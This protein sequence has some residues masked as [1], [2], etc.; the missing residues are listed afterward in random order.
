MLA[1]ASGKGG[2][3]KTTTALGLAASLPARPLVVD[4][5]RAMPNLHEM[6]D[7]SRQPS[8]DDVLASPTAQPQEAPAHDCRVLP[9]PTSE[10]VRIDLVCSRL[11]QS[12]RWDPSAII[13]DCPAG[14]SIDAAAP[15]SAADAVVLVSTACATA[16]RDTA[17]TASMARAVDTSVLGVVL[18]R[19]RLQPPGVESL[20]DAPVLARVPPVEGDPL[21]NRCVRDRYRAAAHRLTERLG[22]GESDSSSTD[23]RRAENVFRG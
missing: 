3:G 23:V 8:V 21:S 2:V 17:K 5:D 9:A 18:T 6:A 19:A 1:I 11:R 15:L 4:A 14:A 7:V 16:L 20:L 12:P 10:T 13:V 22:T